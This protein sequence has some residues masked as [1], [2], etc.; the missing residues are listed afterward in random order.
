MRIF[1]PLI[2]QVNSLHLDPQ[3]KAN[4]RHPRKNQKH[5]TSYHHH[6]SKN[7]QPPK[8]TVLS[9]EDCAGN[10]AACQCRST[11]TSEEDP[12]PHTYLR[13]VGRD[14]AKQGRYHPYKGSRRKAV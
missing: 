14:L 7:L 5:N 6:T 13:Y 1:T 8:G 9:T 3:H 10:R 2:T 11:D 4:Q 12:L